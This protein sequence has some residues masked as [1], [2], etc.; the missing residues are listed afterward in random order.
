M[1]LTD[2]SLSEAA[3]YIQ[4]REVSAV[5]LTQACLERIGQVETQINAFIGVFA[6]QALQAARQ[7]DAELARGEYRGA[8]HGIPLAVKDLY[9][10]ADM[11]TTAGAKFSLVSEEE[12][13]AEAVR[14][15]RLAGA[16]LLGKLN[17]HEIAL[18]VT[19]ENPHFGNCRNPWD[20]TRIT[21]GSSGG[22]AAALAAGMIFGAL[23]SDTG[24]SIRI[25]A[26][27]CGI[28]GLKPTRGRVS[29]RGVVPLSWSLDHA[30]PMAR[31][32]RDTAI[33]LEAI[34]AYDPD[35]PCSVNVPSHNY[36]AHI[37]KGVKGWR[38]ALADDDFF[39]DADAQVLSAVQ[40]A[41]ALFEQ[42]GARLERVAIPY[43]LEAAQTNVRLVTC[44]AAA[45]HRE[46][47]ETRPQDFGADVL[48]R[49]RSGA[50]LSGGEYSLLRRKQALITRWFERFFEK[51][52]L[53]LTPTAPVT[54]PPIGEVNAVVRARQLTRFTAP[55]NLSG[56]PA[57]S[58]NC[59]FSAEGLPI[60]L[61][62]VA[63]HWKEAALLQA[64]YAYEQA[65]QPHLEA[66]RK[67]ANIHSLIA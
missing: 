32:V 17:M 4:R 62:M 36:L 43:G 37:E 42:M 61:Q 45:F 10:T 38:I 51:Y 54:A 18:G 9:A 7:A 14:K 59:G 21:G 63:H 16:V 56:L 30:G 58:I 15:L 64:A 52:D 44:D 35:D 49:L 26:A 67:Q 12:G 65:A 5:E 39:N 46:R 55:F 3:G 11:P 40:A 50:T 29:L 2:L 31:Q 25:P 20:T 48:E 66:S 53:L 47:M 27:L 28:V 13:D 24:G 8:L 33:L 57:I 23:G 6:E 1:A 60:G 34:A 41:T 19:N 22:C